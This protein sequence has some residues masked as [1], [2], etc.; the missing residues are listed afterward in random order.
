MTR[1]NHN[2]ILHTV[3]AM[4]DKVYSKAATMREAL[5]TNIMSWI[6]R[7]TTLQCNK[8]SRRENNGNYLP[9][10]NFAERKRNIRAHAMVNILVSHRENQQLMNMTSNHGLLSE[11]KCQWELKHINTTKPSQIEYPKGY[12]IKTT[13]KPINQKQPAAVDSLVQVVLDPK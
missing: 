9:S 4:I 11:W 10:T 12:T 8:H 6:H 1:S 5:T 2:A 3:L 7:M 13:E